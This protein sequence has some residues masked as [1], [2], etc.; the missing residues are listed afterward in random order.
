MSTINIH[1][2]AHVRTYSPSPPSAA[3]CLWASSESLCKRLLCLWRHR[4][5]VKK[6]GIGPCVCCTV[7]CMLCWHREG[8]LA[9][10]I[11]LY[12]MWLPLLIHPAFTCHESLMKAAI[13][14]TFDL[15]L[16]SAKLS[17]QRR[18]SGG[19]DR[20]LYRLYCTYISLPQCLPMYIN[21]I[22][23]C[24]CGV[25]ICTQYTSLMRNCPQ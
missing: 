18:S 14:E 10:C 13:A 5:G 3:C 2:H 1:A 15:F 20:T 16:L 17:M 4:E 25:Y 21:I 8:A 23:I 6:E 24:C 19:G 9:W 11:Q 22:Y 7:W 12:L